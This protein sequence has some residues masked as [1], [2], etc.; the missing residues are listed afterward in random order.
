MNRGSGVN[1]TQRRCKERCLGS[2]VARVGSDLLSP[3]TRLRPSPRRPHPAGLHAP[4]VG[5]A[6]GTARSL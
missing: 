2:K 5:A 4:V 3:Q 1:V 6:T